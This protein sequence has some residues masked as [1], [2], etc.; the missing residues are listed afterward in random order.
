MVNEYRFADAS[1]VTLCTVAHGPSEKPRATGRT[2]GNDVDGNPLTEWQNADGT[3]C[4][5]PLVRVHESGIL[6]GCLDVSS[7]PDGAS[8]HV[9]T[10]DD[11]WVIAH[12]EADAEQLCVE[13]GFGPGSY[14]SDCQWVQCD[15]AKPFTYF[16]GNDAITKTFS[17]WAAEKG[18][19]YFA[20][21]DY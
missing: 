15:G 16:D 10:N 7:P 19:C 18:R 4:V 12:S 14:T 20:S 5:H 6:T 9:F 11:E 13:L 3:T 21:V 8:L 1:T 2:F 17:E